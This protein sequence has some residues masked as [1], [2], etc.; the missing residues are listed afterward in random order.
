MYCE[1][2]EVFVDA[3]PAGCIADGGGHRDDK[4]GGSSCAGT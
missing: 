2:G 1:R 3:E 4:V